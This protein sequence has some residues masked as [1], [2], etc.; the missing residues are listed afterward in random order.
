LLCQFCEEFLAKSM[1][2]EI[3]KNRGEGGGVVNQ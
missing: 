3:L 2:L 1:I